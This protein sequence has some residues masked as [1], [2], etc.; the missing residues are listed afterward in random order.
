MSLGL[1]GFSVTAFFSFPLK[2]F[3]PV[4]IVMLFFGLI[5]RTLTLED[6][7]IN[8]KI[9][10]KFNLPIRILVLILMFVSISYAFNTLFS[11][12][13]YSKSLI[14]HNQNQWQDALKLSTKSL[15]FNSFNDKSMF[16]QAK[17]YT[18]TQQLKKS[19]AVYHALLKKRPYNSGALFNL[20]AAYFNSGNMQ[21][22][23]KYL[24]QVLQLYPQ[25]IKANLVY[26]SLL[27]FNKKHT[28]AIAQY[29]KTKKIAFKQKTNYENLG[30][31]AQTIKLY[32][33]AKIAFQF[34]IQYAKKKDSAMAKLGILMFYF[35]NEKKQGL[36]LMFQALKLNPNVAQAKLLKKTLKP[37]IK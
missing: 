7:K 15:E 21:N 17:S 22:G 29:Y 10:K 14:A 16:L 1:L 19:I 28:E 33:E 20:S 30:D 11:K 36:Q 34:A 18:Q 24:N 35:L 4:F 13:Y 31:K 6:K 3:L 26:I 9:A 32:K 37:Y 2:V 27:N 5:E 25:H 23:I 8:F 12:H